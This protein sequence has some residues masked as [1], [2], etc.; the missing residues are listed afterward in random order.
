MTG[1]QYQHAIDKLGMTQ[2]GSS[3]FF[4]IAER[5]PRKWIKGTSPIPAAV[6]M[7]LCVMMHYSLTPENVMH[8]AHRDRVAQ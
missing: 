6:E 8:I 5:T 4:D 7:L 2:V 3:R 1:E